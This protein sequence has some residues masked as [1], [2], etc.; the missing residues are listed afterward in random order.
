MKKYSNIE[1]YSQHGDLIFR[2]SEKKANWYLNKNLAKVISVDDEKNPIR[3]ELLFKTKGNGA[4]DDRYT[5]EY[6]ENRCVVCGNVD[7]KVLTK[8]HVIP[9]CYRRYFPNKYKDYLMHDVL[10]LCRECHNAYEKTSWIEKKKIAEKYGITMDGYNEDTKVHTYIAKIASNLVKH[11]HKMPKN[12]YD[13]LISIIELETDQVCTMEYLHSIRF[14]AHENTIAFGKLIV[15]KLE[16]I[17]EFIVFWRN[18]F[19]ITMK[20]MFLSE[21]WKV[22]NS[23]SI[24]E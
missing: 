4:K 3:I 2:T 14:N 5:L 12:V 10:V 18:H 8:H 16:N 9:Y 23:C 11:G 1:V 15:D 19:V 17:E 6:K 20:P 24:A 22:D 21:N 7:E 13:N